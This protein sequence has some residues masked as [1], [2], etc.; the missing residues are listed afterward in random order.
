MSELSSIIKQLEALRDATAEKSAIE[1]ERIDEAL[2]ALNPGRPVQYAPERELPRD[3]V[4]SA[5][6]AERPIAFDYPS[7]DGLVERRFLSPYQVQESATGAESVVGWDHN[8]EA[9]RQFRLDRIG[10]GGV[11]VEPLALDYRR[12]QD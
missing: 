12:P 6:E 10:S 1:L 8:R 9:I 11:I 4:L 5:I 3:A 2:A 7:G